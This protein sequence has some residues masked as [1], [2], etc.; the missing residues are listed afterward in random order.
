MRKIRLRF[1]TAMLL[2]VGAGSSL[3]A[4]HYV[5]VNSANATPPYTNWTTAATS[6]QPAV[7][8][9]AAGDGI[10]VTNGTYTI[11]GGMAFYVVA[12]DKP[13]TLRSS[14]GPEFTTIDGGHSAVCVYLADGASLSGFT[15]TK[16]FGDCI[17]GGVLCQSQAAVV[18]N[19]VISGNSAACDVMFTADG[20]GAAG[21]TLNNCT[22]SGNG[23]ND[24]GGAY[25]CTLNSCIV[26]GNGAA[27]VA[28]VV[29]GFYFDGGCGGGVANC[30]LNNCTLTSNSAF[31]GGGAWCVLNNC[32]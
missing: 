6:I 18:S 29:L 27:P 14:N 23:A 12:V 11:T 30:T 20:G 28:D 24:G 10:M 9:A 16:G 1:L 3:A 2:L 7:D 5:D 4:T 32:T 13:L 21:G 25:G 26:V 22:L 15:V 8:A 19:C 17:S 31:L